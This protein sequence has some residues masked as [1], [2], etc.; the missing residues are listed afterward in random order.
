MPDPKCF[1]RFVGRTSLAL[2]AALTLA[3]L[4]AGIAPLTAAGVLALFAAGYAY[5]YTLTGSF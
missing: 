3:G 1:A 5:A 4:T 2:A